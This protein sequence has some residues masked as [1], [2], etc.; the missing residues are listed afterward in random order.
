MENTKGVL[1]EWTAIQWTEANTGEVVEDDPVQFSFRDDKTY[2]IDYGTEKEEG[3][4]W[5]EGKRLY[6]KEEE[7]IAKKVM[8]EN[9]K[10]DTLVIAMNRFGQLETLVLAR[11]K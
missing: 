4:Y 5:L 11:N 8:L 3:I 2:T 1:G 6:T 10:Q 9:V 7:G